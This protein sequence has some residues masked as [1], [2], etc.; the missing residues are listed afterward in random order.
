VGLLFERG[1]PHT[2][3]SFAAC[4]FLSVTTTGA[5]ARRCLIQALARRCL[6]QHQQSILSKKRDET[7]IPTIGCAPRAGIFTSSSNAYPGVIIRHSFEV[8]RC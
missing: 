3:H 6:I 1:R 8:K 7:F 4:S 5:L 2:G